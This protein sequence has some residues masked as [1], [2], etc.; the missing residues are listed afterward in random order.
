MLK[1]W[2]EPCGIISLFWTVSSLG[3]YCLYIFFISDFKV[4]DTHAYALNPAGMF[5]VVF[6]LFIFLRDN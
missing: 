3:M 4:E 1:V 6:D 5:S 2:Y